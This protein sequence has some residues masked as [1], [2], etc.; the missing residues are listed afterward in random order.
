MWQNAHYFTNYFL[1]QKLLSEQKLLSCYA[2]LRLQRIVYGIKS[3]IIIKFAAKVN[4][5]LHVCFRFINDSSSSVD[6]V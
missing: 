6:E 5:Q 3:P 1:S 4:I 2:F